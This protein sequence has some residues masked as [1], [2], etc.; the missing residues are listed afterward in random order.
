[1][2]LRVITQMNNLYRA[3]PRTYVRTVHTSGRRPRLAHTNPCAEIYGN[4]IRFHITPYSYHINLMHYVI[5][6]N[7]LFPL[8]A[9]CCFKFFYGIFQIAINLFQL[10]AEVFNY[11]HIEGKNFP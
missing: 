7:C 3:S 4:T 6:H 5:E 11:Y 10:R 1:M 2:Q 9:L 8:S